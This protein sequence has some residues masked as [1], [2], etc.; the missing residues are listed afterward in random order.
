MK[1]VLVHVSGS[2]VVVD[3]L[4]SR[5]PYGEVD[6]AH[7][8]SSAEGVGYDD[9]Y[10][11]SREFSDRNADTIGGGIRSRGNNV[12]ISF[13][14]ATFEASTP[15]FAQMNP[16]LV[17]VIKCPAFILTIFRVSRRITSTWR[18]SLP[19]S[20][21]T[22]DAIGEGVTFDRFTTRPSAFDTTF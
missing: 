10:H 3:R 20:L 22:R 4:H 21:A 11:F 19:A 17:S 8:P 1:S 2:P 14:F 18:G 12:T 13:P 7:P 15:A 6:L 9:G 5:Y 16:C